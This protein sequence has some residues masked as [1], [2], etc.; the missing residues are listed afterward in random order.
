MKNLITIF[1]FLMLCLVAV[2]S[3]YAM[4]ESSTQPTI[5]AGDNTNPSK[6]RTTITMN[7]IKTLSIKELEAKSGHKLTWKQK[8]GLKLAKNKLAKDAGEGSVGLGFVLGFLLG[9]IGVLVA[10]LAFKEEKKTIKGAWYG[11]LASLAL[12]LIIIVIFVAAVPK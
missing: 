1:S 10:Y 2:P 9:L 5:A 8:L 3:S 11:L 6:E 4:V 12:A 7:D